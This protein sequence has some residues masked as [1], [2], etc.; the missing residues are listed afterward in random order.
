MQICLDNNPSKYQIKRFEPPKIWINDIIYKTNLIVTPEHLFPHWRPQSAI[1]IIAGDF[2]ALLT[3]PIEILLIGTG[4]KLHFLPP[5]LTHF[6]FSKKIGV[7]IMT[8]DA[9][10]RTYVVL[11]SEQ[12]KVAA[13][14]ILE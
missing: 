2:E 3:L 5:T 6:F 11:S 9:A 12:R 4:S 10:I 7:E 1:E 13:A 8:T 14:L